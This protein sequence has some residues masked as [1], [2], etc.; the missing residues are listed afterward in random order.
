MTLIE[1]L[2]NIRFAYVTSDAADEPLIIQLAAGD[3]LK[4][5]E[6][7]ALAASPGDS[8]LFAADGKAFPRLASDPGSIAA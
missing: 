1:S 2:G 3:R 4:E 8:H 5:G 6:K 7:I